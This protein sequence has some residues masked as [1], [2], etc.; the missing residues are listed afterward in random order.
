MSA[1]GDAAWVDDIKE[2]VKRI[3][4]YTKRVGYQSFLKNKK[5]QDAVV[6]N[7]EIIGEAAKNISADFKQIHND[8]DWKRIAGM[9]DK[10]VHHYFGVNWEIVWDVVKNKVPQLKSELDKLPKPSEYG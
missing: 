1:R 5:T 4:R 2:A 6:R 8:V 10:L 3:E 9:R 7:L